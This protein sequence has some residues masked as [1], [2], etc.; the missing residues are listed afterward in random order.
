MSMMSL[1]FPLLCNEIFVKPKLNQSS[2]ISFI[3]NFDLFD[4]EHHYQMT[5]EVEVC[6][7]KMSL[8]LH[9]CDDV[10]CLHSDVILAKVF[11]FFFS[12]RLSNVP[13][14]GHAWL[15]TLTQ[16]LCYIGFFFLFCRV[17]L[18]RKDD[19]WDGKWIVE[20]FSSSFIAQIFG[21]HIKCRVAKF[22]I[23]NIWLMG[24]DWLNFNRGMERHF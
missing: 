4:I 14:L 19:N 13:L 15:H 12:F 24:C 20:K 6:L 3:L 1:K 9:M 7:A 16:C 8:A 17:N 22:S 2:Q 21:L 5:P 11:F 23:P 18:I 10:F